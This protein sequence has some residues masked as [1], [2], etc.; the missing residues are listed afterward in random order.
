VRE[1]FAGDLLGNVWRIDLLANPA[2]AGAVTRLAQPRDPSNNPQ[3]VTAAPELM[4]WQG[5]RVVLVGTG[6][7]LDPSDFG[8]SRV[9]SFYAIAAGTPLT[10]TRSQLVQRNLNVAGNGSITGADFSWATQR[11][12]YLDL[13]AGEQVNHRPA[14]ANGA[15]AFVANKIGGSDCAASARLVVVDVLTGGRFPRSEFVTTMLSETS[16]TSGVTALLTRDGQTLRFN[17]RDYSSGKGVGRG[18]SAGVPITP[19]KNSWREIRR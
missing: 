18:I 10:N 11:G 13:P 8:S 7:L 14:L 2:A 3:P 17:A 5:Q 16:N 9:Q 15:V 4:A 12:W 1:V 19:L 6:R